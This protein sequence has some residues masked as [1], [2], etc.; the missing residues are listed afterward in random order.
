MVVISHVS[1]WL[2]RSVS[3]QEQEHSAR[4]SGRT[5]SGTCGR[6]CGRSVPTQGAVFEIWSV[7]AGV[8]TGEVSYCVIFFFFFY[9]YIQNSH[10]IINKNKLSYIWASATCT[11]IG[12]SAMGQRKLDLAP[13]MHIIADLNKEKLNLHLSHPITIP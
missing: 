1:N 11:A 13:R 5:S 7:A 6:T 2:I 9:G 10:Y 4:H 3:V 12:A 8:E